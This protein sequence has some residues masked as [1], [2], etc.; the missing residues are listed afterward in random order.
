MFTRLHNLLHRQLDRWLFRVGAPEPAPILL[1]QR[2][3]FVLPTSAGLAFAAA[4]LAML[5]A[6]INY[7]L[8]LGYGLV[9]LLAGVA[10]ASIVH[11]FRNLL[12]LS[13][14]PGRAAPAFAGETASF[15]LLVTSTRDTRRPALRLRAHGADVS[16]ELAAG[17]TAELVLPCKTRT[18]GWMPL[19]RVVIETFYPLGLIR[20]WSVLV[21]DLNGLVYPAPEADPPP[22]PTGISDSTGH[23]TVRTGDDDFAGLRVHQIADSPRHVAWKVVAR[24]GPMLTK[25]FAGLH[26]GELTLD[27]NRL[28]EHLDREARLAR[29]AAWVLAAAGQGLAF[30]LV[31]PDGASGVASGS[32]H[33]HDC[34]RRLALFEP[35]PDRDG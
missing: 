21:P 9:F 1:G 7:N 19:G 25:Q 33:L 23:R 8:S 30:A 27:W 10:I 31:L 2:R 18:R 20:A 15:R 22:I 11:A 5:I 26:G 12:N 13:L 29:L 3:I 14:Q 32:G 24:G 28:P 4:L 16:F 6:S 34:L 17:E 35:L